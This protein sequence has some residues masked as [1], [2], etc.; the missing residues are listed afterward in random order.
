[1]Y[2]C[3]RAGEN[4]FGAEEA[5][6]ERG[7]LASGPSERVSTGRC[8][9]RDVLAVVRVRYDHPRLSTIAIALGDV[10]HGRLGTVDVV[11][12][13]VDA[14]RLVVCC[15]S[16]ELE[17]AS[18]LVAPIKRF[19][20]IFERWPLLRRQRCAATSYAL[21]EPLA[22]RRDSAESDWPTRIER[23]RQSCTCP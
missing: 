23:T 12:G 10:G 14:A 11:D 9:K 20:E 1:M 13:A 17:R 5:R 2:P 21:R 4:D 22:S 6:L 3:E 16:A 8:P 18:V 19:S 15:V 7:V